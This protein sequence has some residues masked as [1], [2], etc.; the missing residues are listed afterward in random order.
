MRYPKAVEGLKH[1]EEIKSFL[2]WRSRQ[3]KLKQQEDST[4]ECLSESDCTTDEELEQLSSIR[5]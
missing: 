1:A 4:E 2:L 3:K 5:M